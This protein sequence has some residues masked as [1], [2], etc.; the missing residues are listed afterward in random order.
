MMNDDDKTIF[1]PQ[2]YIRLR[3]SFEIMKQD[4]LI[5]IILK[6][7]KT[8]NR[9]SP[10]FLY[11][12]RAYNVLIKKIGMYPI[13]NSKVIESMDITPNMK[14]KL[15]EWIKIR[16]PIDFEYKLRTIT[17]IGSKLAKQLVDSGVDS[18]AKL[19]SKKVFDKLPI[20]TQ[21]DLIYKP[22]KRIPRHIIEYVEDITKSNKIPFVYVGS[23][24]RGSSSSSDM[25][26]LIK[27][28]NPLP[29]NF[30]ESLNKK[31]GT[32]VY[33]YEPYASGNSKIS[34]ILNIKKYKV[35][36]KMDIF[37][38]NTV[39]YPFALLYSTGSKEFNIM[40]RSKCKKKG[41]LLNQKGLYKS[42]GS[43]IKCVSEKDIFKAVGMK[44]VL[45]TKR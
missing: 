1:F 43:L 24:R 15:N 41:L 45:P 11:E 33:F 25:D 21:I 39:E 27:R 42:D 38:T 22:I 10:N 16:D 35:K 12:I 34:T 3:T 20:A 13:I 9:K 14:N 26:V 32:Y 4:V 30:I 40:M 37:I 28:N 5:A 44:Y 2:I 36:V 6:Y 23:Y 31:I 19:K 8:L 7:I 18:M 17:G 29:S